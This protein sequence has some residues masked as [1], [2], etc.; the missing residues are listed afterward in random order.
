MSKISYS[1]PFTKEQH[2]HLVDIIVNAFISME[3]RNI[4]KSEHSR[5]FNNMEK[6]YDN[7]FDEFIQ[8]NYKKYDLPDGY[9]KLLGSSEY[10]KIRFKMMN[11]AEKKMVVW[12]R[13]FGRTKRKN[14]LSDI[15]EASEELSDIPSEISDSVEKTVEKVMPKSKN[16]AGWFDR[17]FFTG[18]KTKKKSKKE[19]KSKKGNKH[20]KGKKHH[21]GTNKSKNRKKT[22]KRR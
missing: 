7:K 12:K 9:P 6:K 19:K 2:N 10:K 18:A 5:I 17:L 11:E 3:R 20:H 1:N 14:S 13:K 16:P 15:R 22:I 8:S 21:K 4:S